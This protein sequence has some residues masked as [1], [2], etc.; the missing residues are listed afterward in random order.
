MKQITG[1]TPV[2]LAR[3]ASKKAEEEQNKEAGSS[4]LIQKFNNHTESNKQK[5]KGQ[6]LE[7]LMQTNAAKKGAQILGANPWR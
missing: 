3:E 5:P 1:Y 6:A 4:S 7:K 2:T